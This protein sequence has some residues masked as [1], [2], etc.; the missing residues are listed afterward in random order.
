MKNVL[1][2]VMCVVLCAGA[3]QAALDDIVLEEVVKDGIHY[4]VG[5]DEIPARVLN[6]KKTPPRRSFHWVCSAMPPNVETVRRHCSWRSTDTVREDLFNL[7]TG[8]G[9]FREMRRSDR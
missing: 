6:F 3:A 4:V 7:R 1:F 5:A 9:G 2:M 8:P